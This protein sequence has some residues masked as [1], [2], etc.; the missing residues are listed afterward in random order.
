MGTV[1]TKGCGGKGK[2]ACY[3]RQNQTAVCPDQALGSK[4]VSAFHSGT[5]RLC[6]NYTVLQG[7]V[8]ATHLRFKVKF[9]VTEKF[10][11]E[12]DVHVTAK[13][14]QPPKPFTLATPA[15]TKVGA[16]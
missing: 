4:G 14:L 5:N 6:R 3:L 9:P 1:G 16:F 11:E 7:N 15:S 12:G 8:R 2:N 10:Q 13:L